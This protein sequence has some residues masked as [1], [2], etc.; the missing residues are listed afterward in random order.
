MTTRPKSRLATCLTLA[1]ALLAACDDD[2]VEPVACEADTSEVT[3]TIE[4]NGSVVF[5]WSPECSVFLVLVEEEASDVWGIQTMDQENGITPPVTYGTVPAGVE[6][7]M[8][9]DPLVAG[10]TY[11][12][13]LWRKLPGDVASLAEVQEFTR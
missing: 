6:E 2:G 3:A 5:D 13:I 4:T 8:A 10:Q 9:P 11:E 1:L 7:L 12:L